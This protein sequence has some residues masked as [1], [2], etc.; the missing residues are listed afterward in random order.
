MRFQSVDEFLRSGFRPRV[1]IVGTG[2]AGISLALRLQE[3]KVPCLLVEAGGYEFSQTSQDFYRGDVIGDH[4]HELHEARL[5]QFG[6]TSGHWSGW[7]CPL[8]ASDFEPRTYMAYSGWPIRSSDLEP[9]RSAADE[10]LQ[11]IARL[12]DRSMTQ[13]IDYIHYRFSPPT[14]FGTVYRATVEQSKTIGL[15]LNTPVLELVPGK[16]RIESIKVSQGSSTADIRVDHVCVCTGGIEN[17]R[18]LLWSNA[19]HAGGVVPH[20]AALGRYWMEH[21]VHVLADV[22]TSHGYEMQ[23]ETPTPDKWY[24]EIGRA[25]V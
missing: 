18:L 16:D 3:R 12:P 6:G 8:D 13:D 24:F 9:Y 21:P 25:H 15:L 19:R 10:L 20:A 22:V 4:Y 5:R 7:V 23:F 2:P 1:C 11:V 17:S 14:R